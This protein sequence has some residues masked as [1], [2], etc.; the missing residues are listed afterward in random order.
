MKSKIWNYGNGRWYNGV[1]LLNFSIA[2][3]RITWNDAQ[4]GTWYKQIVRVRNVLKL[5]IQ[6]APT[7]FVR[8]G[9]RN[10]GTST[11]LYII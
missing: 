3:D 1:W 2:S 10:S 5:Q 9:S 7:R 6:A 4:R 8:V 11:V